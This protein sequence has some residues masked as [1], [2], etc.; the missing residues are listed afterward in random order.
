M[1]FNSFAFLVFFPIVT[2]IY[3]LLPHRFRWLWLLI[4]SCVFYMFFIPKYIIILFITISIDYWAG[5]KIAESTGMVRKRYLWISIISTI[6]VLAIFKYANFFNANL[7]LLAHVLNWNY[8]LSALGI[9]LPIGLSFH[10][11]QSL[12][13][14]IEVYRGHQKPERNFGIYSL[15]VMFY[16]QLV[17]GPI[18]RPQNILYQF[19]ERHKFK[20]ED[21]ASGLKLMA[22]GFFKKLIIADRLSM[23]INPVY[24]NPGH[25]SGVTLIFATLLFAQQ[26]YCDFSGYSD[27]A[28]GIA[29]IMG[30]RLMKNFDCPYFSKSVSEFWSRWHISLSTW[31][32]DYIYIPMGGSR[33]AKWRWYYNLLIT[34][35]LSGLWHGAN[36]TFVAWGALNGFYLIIE[37]HTKAQRRR[38]SEI[39]GLAKFPA[40]LNLLQMVT[41]FILITISW[42]FFRANTMSDAILIFSKMFQA[43][44]FN[45]DFK[46]FTDS[47][48][49]FLSI[50]FIL[51]LE[52]IQAFHKKYDILKFIS[53]RPLYFRLGLY[54]CFLVILLNFGI[55]SSKGFI[56]FQF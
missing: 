44:P 10:T 3:F 55:F 33:V 4:M 54:T 37:A 42:T 35:L 15:Y 16:P 24:N 52:F 27:I 47:Y 29:R 1:L 40:V 45:I 28:I 46:S 43:D 30:F 31:F 20:Y 25:Y 22:W 17:A 18:E 36:W 49:L 2:F 19:Y 5:I 13:Y 12:S 34:F 51:L 53:A 6:L 41:T 23:V 39:I 8:S 7:S 32:R 21:A 11:F 14:V 38:L 50:F 9:I 26:I 48:S 56:Y